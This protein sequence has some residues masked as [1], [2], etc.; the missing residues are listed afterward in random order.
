M[1]ALLKLSADRITKEMQA[2]RLSQEALNQL[3]QR[4]I[5]RP[6]DRYVDGIH[7][8]A[9]NIIDKNGYRTVYYTNN[10]KIPGVLT[11]NEIAAKYGYHPNNFGSAYTDPEKKVVI[12]RHPSDIKN[13]YEALNNA[14]F[15]FH[16]ANEALYGNKTPNV[17]TQMMAP[18]SKS[19]LAKNKLEMMDF[20]EAHRPVYEKMQKELKG[21]HINNAE[22]MQLSAKYSLHPESEKRAL[23]IFKEYL[24]GKRP[25]L[26]STVGLHVSPKVLLNE[27]DAISKIPYR[28]KLKDVYGINSAGLLALR[29]VTDE[30]NYLKRVLGRDPYM[31]GKRAGDAKKIDRDVMRNREKFDIGKRTINVIKTSPASKV[32]ERIFE[33]DQI[34]NI[35][36]EKKSLYETSRKMYGLD[37]KDE[38]PNQSKNIPTSNKPSISKKLSLMERVK[39]A[40]P[41]ALKRLLK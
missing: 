30:R 38:T 35:I 26:H 9:N 41:R 36:N 37:F 13:K 20:Y 8:G 18:V 28:D 29:D 17:I 10:K 27:A 22:A 21:K 3:K 16:E 2:G 34:K 5:I 11:A 19:P 31:T 33:P 32:P 7:K 39:K 1:N 24:E 6:V 4:E 12:A 15:H 14:I 40:A 25:D 23:H